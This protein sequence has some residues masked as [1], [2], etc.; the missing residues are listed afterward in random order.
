VTD[1]TQTPVDAEVNAQWALHGKRLDRQG[2]R[3]LACSTGKVR[4]PE[5]EKEAIGRFS[6]GTPGTLPQ[7]TV[8]YLQPATQPGASYLALATHEYADEIN[9]DDDQQPRYDDDGRR[10]MVTSYFCVPYDP[11]AKGSVSYQSMYQE[12]G[13][14]RLAPQDGPPIPVE[15]TRQ[16]TVT[17]AIDDLAVHSAALLVTGRPVCVLGAQDTTVADRLAFVDTVMALLPYGLRSRMTAATWTRPTYRDHRFRLFFSDAARATDPPDH[18][19]DWRDP[20]QAPPFTPADNYAAEYLLWLKD[21]VS[22]PTAELAKLTDPIGFSRHDILAFLDRIGVASQDSPE[23]NHSATGQDVLHAR[24]A[25]QTGTA[26]GTGAGEKILRD[27]ARHAQAGSEY[28]IGSD[29]QRLNSMVNSGDGAGER[30]R[31]REIIKETGLLQLT[32]TLGTTAGRLYEQLFRVAFTVPLDYEAYCQVED[33][34]KRPPTHPALLRA[35]DGV[36]M[37]DPRVAAIVC[38]QLKNTDPERP[39]TWC[40]SELEAVELI[41][42]LA[43]KW[44]RPPHARIVCDVILD[45]LNGMRSRTDANTIRSQLLQQGFLAEA[46]KANGVGDDQYQVTRLHEFLERAYPDGLSRPEIEQVLTCCAPR[47]PTPALLGAV[48]LHLSD[49]A[50]LPKAYMTYA[51]DSISQGGFARATTSRMLETLSSPYS[52]NTDEL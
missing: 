20:A 38:W 39:G 30:A 1:L 2:Y 41:R 52:R 16:P 3:V 33:C 32:E 29:I 6:P 49:D 44:E 27:C 25:R 21:T 5:F 51:Y 42:L 43:D 47:L 24:P 35:I 45:H 40:S 50:D 4:R 19:L 28:L 34:L 36:G 13:P 12:L 26:A 18:I 48:V 14:I 10:I 11:L 8:S 37:A 15:L 31:Y 46:L 23:L 9:S 17:H 22:R 7:V